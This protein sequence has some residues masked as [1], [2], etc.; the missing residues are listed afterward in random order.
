[1]PHL[2]EHKPLRE[3]TEASYHAKDIEADARPQESLLLSLPAE[4]R[5]KVYEHV[6]SYSDTGLRI[7]ATVLASSS[8]LPEVSKQVRDEF[9]AQVF[10]TAPTIRV[11]VRNFDFSHIVTFFNRLSD[12]ELRALPTT[13][14]P[15]DR[16][17]TI[18]ITITNAIW[19]HTEGLFR[20]L[21]RL[22]HPT[23]KGTSVDVSHKVHHDSRV[24]WE[25]I[26]KLWTEW[27]RMDEGRAKQNLT[28]IIEAMR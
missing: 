23:K 10:L 28:L 1:M 5:N 7:G 27:D 11:L 3:E 13:N 20:G 2:L 17:M 24:D 14:L 16:K 9:L 22:D 12:S 4:L 18:E 19:Y 8:A 6:A 26:E 21:R 15:T 25:D